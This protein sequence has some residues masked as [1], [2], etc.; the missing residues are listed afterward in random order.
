MIIVVSFKTLILAMYEYNNELSKLLK[1]EKQTSMTFTNK[2]SF[3]SFLIKV[4]DVQSMLFI[5]NLMNSIMYVLFQIFFSVSML[6]RC[7]ES[8]KSRIPDNYF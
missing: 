7:S 2:T 6:V 4:N 1:L 3:F 8:T 5:Q